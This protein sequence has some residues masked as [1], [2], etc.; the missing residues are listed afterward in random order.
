MLDGKV[1]LVTGAT[2]GIGKAIAEA[3]ARDGATVTSGGRV[4]CVTALAENAKAARQVAYE[5]IHGIR[6]DGMQFR[7]DIGQRAMKPGSE[8]TAGP[9]ARGAGRKGGPLGRACTARSSCSK[10][11]G[12][13]SPAPARLAAPSSS[14]SRPAMASDRS[15]SLSSLQIAA[16]RSTP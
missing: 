15:A 6:F 2:R 7:Q 4:L 16:A 13:L 3:L 5:A 14:S 12:P 9:G 10:P 11:M 8:G 1:A